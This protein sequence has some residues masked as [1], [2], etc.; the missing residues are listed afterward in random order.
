M[1][2]ELAKKIVCNE[3]IAITARIRSNPKLYFLNPYMCIGSR[4]SYYLMHWLP[5]QQQKRLPFLFFSP[6]S[7][8]PDCFSSPHLQFGALCWHLNSCAMSV[9]VPLQSGSTVHTLCASMNY[10]AG[11]QTVAIRPTPSTLSW[12][13]CFLLSSCSLNLKDHC[14]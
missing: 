4:S 12:R 11:F 2:C 9:N 1:G 14:H 3:V 10:L 6:P 7:P 13:H 8:L 5:Q